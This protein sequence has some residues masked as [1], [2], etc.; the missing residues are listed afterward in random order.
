M[1]VAKAADT[2]TT[3]IDLGNQDVTVSITI[4]W[5]LV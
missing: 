3:E 5:S 4:R 2:G 1:G